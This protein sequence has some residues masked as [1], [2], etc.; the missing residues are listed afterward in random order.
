VSV[1]GTIAFLLEEVYTIV[2]QQ[3][4]SQPRRIMTQLEEKTWDTTDFNTYYR[5]TEDPRVLEAVFRDDEP[6]APDGDAYM[7]AYYV[8]YCGAWCNAGMIGS[9]YAADDELS[10]YLEARNEL[11]DHDLAAR[12]M[13]IFHETTVTEHWAGN[14]ARFVV[15]NT[16]S[17]RKH[18]GMETM[19]TEASDY[20]A[21]ITGDVWAVGHLIN[22][23]RVLDDE[24]VD[25]SDGNW[26][27]E[28]ECHG[29]YGLEYAQGSLQDFNLPDMDVLLD[30]PA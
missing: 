25:I 15:L 23:G 5:E 12:F 8:D 6:F 29:F 28:T 3:H 30:I 26:E 21:Y 27:R 22:A 18:V 24:D 9:V 11:G 4:P 16:P 2:Y 7:P 1:S 10:A 14:Y 13:A 19:T 17:F 20:I